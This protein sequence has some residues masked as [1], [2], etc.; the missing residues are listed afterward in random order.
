MKMH[1][2]KDMEAELYRLQL[3][4]QKLEKEILKNWKEIKE[5]GDPGIIAGEI[6]IN[7][8]MGKSDSTDRIMDLAE[9]LLGYLRKK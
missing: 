4:Q 9:I 5:K 7:S 2:A 6:A 1:N 8:F 3:R